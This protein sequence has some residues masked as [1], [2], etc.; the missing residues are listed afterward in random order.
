MKIP[1]ME[2][3]LIRKGGMILVAT[4]LGS[5]VSFFANI[6]I[7]NILGPKLFG[8]FKTIIYLFVF[9]PL[10]V[11]L[12]INASLTKYISELGKDRIGEAKHLIR[13]F[14]KVKLLSYVLVISVVF[15]LRGSI[16]LYF[17]KDPSLDYVVLAGM[18]YLGL[19]FFSV[20]NSIMLGMQNFKLFSLSQ[21]LN[22]GTSALMGVILSPFGIFYMI[23]GW[24]MGPLIGSLPSIAYMIKNKM[25]SDCVKFDCKKIFLKF[26]L[27]VYPVELT[28]NLFT[29]IIPL[30]SLFFAQKLVGYYSFAFMFYYVAQLI[31]NSLSSVLFPKV[32]ELHGQGKHEN[33]RG[34]LK[35]SFLYYGI[36]AT[37]GLL[38]V[39][40]LSE[41]FVSIIA[42]EYLPSINMFKVIL[43]LSF[44][45][46]FN[47]IYV[48]YLK[49]LGK[50][51]RYALLSF[52]QNILLMI[53]SFILL[54][55]QI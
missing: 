54:N 5:I 1:F 52:V 27:P 26:S 35:K 31:P 3:D 42:K 28:M 15:L 36:V 47:V 29:V 48:N 17:L 7:S 44:I 18:V 4:L 34:I 41:W 19:T 32:S 49:G 13:W 45:F 30:L 12:G 37:L 43:S 16:S 24:G 46:G 9:L 10:L 25:F 14:L 55:S 6:I 40:T 53:A 8:D 51:R 50:V 2:N 21:F 11:D 20:F 33:A 39:F 38:F 23:L 22:S